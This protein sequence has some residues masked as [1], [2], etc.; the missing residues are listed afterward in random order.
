MDSCDF[1]IFKLLT[2]N[3][4]LCCRCHVLHLFGAQTIAEVPCHVI[5]FR[6]TLQMT[7]GLMHCSVFFTLQMTWEFVFFQPVCPTVSG[8]IAKAAR[9]KSA[10]VRQKA[11]LP[12]LQRS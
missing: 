8:S 3:I 6:G 9:L 1:G 12:Q 7:L 4:S 2:Y 5:F 10:F 11:H